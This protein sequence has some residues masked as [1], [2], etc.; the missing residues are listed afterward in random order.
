MIRLFASWSRLSPCSGSGENLEL[1]RAPGK[2]LHLGHDQHGIADTLHKLH[3][4]DAG[5]DPHVVALFEWGLPDHISGQVLHDVDLARSLWELEQGAPYPGRAPGLDVDPDR[6]LAPCRI[7]PGDVIQANGQLHA[8]VG[9]K[10]DGVPR[11]LV[12][13]GDEGNR[14]TREEP[15]DLLDLEKAILDD[16]LNLLEHREYGVTQFTR[17]G[18]AEI[19]SATAFG[20]TAD[21]A[22]LLLVQRE[23]DN[24]R[25]QFCV[26]CPQRLR[27]RT[28]VAAAGL[29]TVGDQ[30][31]VI[32][33]PFAGLEITTRA[34]QREGDWR[35]T[36]RLGRGDLIA[37][38]RLVDAL[39]G[40]DELRGL[41][42]YGPASLGVV[43]EVAVNAKA[44]VDSFP[45]GERVDDVVHDAFGRFHPGLAASDVARHGAGEIE[46][47]LQIDG[48]NCLLALC[49]CSRRGRSWTS[50]PWQANARRGHDQE[51][52]GE[53]ALHPAQRARQGTH[54][55]TPSSF[56]S[57]SR[58]RSR[59]PA[60]PGLDD[61]I[62]RRF[63][64]VMA[65]GR[66][67]RGITPPHGACQLGRKRCASGRQPGWP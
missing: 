61:P 28:R 22:G 46:D 9:G 63:P 49:R 7:G 30:Q 24:V 48:A 66:G 54:R 25:G 47:E 34:L 55:L 40:N 17:T 43:A 1:R 11:R 56:S 35:P 15:T 8:V 6:D 38:G 32:G 14:G 26:T 21:E 53:R 60:D 3:G 23:S 51:Q 41:T 19:E 65:G 5:E 27:D 42:T 2:R 29:L 45:F 39:D 20:D 36:D 58:R 52:Q 12:A 64:A 57:R 50:K 31:D 18:G 13:G 37:Q 44:D 10:G 33:D 16:N 59:S 4:V 62:V 67:V